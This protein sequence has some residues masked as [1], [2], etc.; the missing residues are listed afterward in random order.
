MPE[1]NKNQRL[2]GT[3]RPPRHMTYMV[4]TPKD[5][6]GEEAAEV[7][8]SKKQPKRQRQRRR[9]KSRRSRDSNTGTGDD[10]TLDGAEDT[11][12]PDEQ[13]AE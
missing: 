1:T 8:S 7:D 2:Q 10:N 4:D 11:E 3:G 9:S 13:T 6:D 12:E 5:G